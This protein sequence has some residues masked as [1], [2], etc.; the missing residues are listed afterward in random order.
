MR[1]LNVKLGLPI[2]LIGW[3]AVDQVHCCRVPYGA[4][5]GRRR[6]VFVLLINGKFCGMLPPPD[7]ALVI[8][9]FRRLIS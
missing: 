7:D 4:L 5:R 3:T 2:L 8:R 6:F 1:M 9:I